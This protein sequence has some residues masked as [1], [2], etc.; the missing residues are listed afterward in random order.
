MKISPE[1]TISRFFNFYVAHMSFLLGLPHS[2]ANMQ[3]IKLEVT[4]NGSCLDCR[5]KW[6]AEIEQKDKDRKDKARLK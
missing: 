1:R 4:S 5:W 3:I 2:F 6:L